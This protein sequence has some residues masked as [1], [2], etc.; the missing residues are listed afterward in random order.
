MN[1]M[2]HDDIM[3]R[4]SLSI[5]NICVKLER[6]GAAILSLTEFQEIPQGETLTVDMFSSFNGRKSF[7]SILDL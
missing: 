5:L 1:Q 7:E 3:G 2:N 4:E 6:L